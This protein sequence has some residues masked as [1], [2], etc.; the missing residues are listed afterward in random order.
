MINE[1]QHS[2]VLAPPTELAPLKLAVIGFLPRFVA[3]TSFLFANPRR[4]LVLPAPREQRQ[5]GAKAYSLLPLH[6]F[7][8][9]ASLEILEAMT[10]RP[11]PRVAVHIQLW[12]CATGPCDV[13]A[14]VTLA[15]QGRQELLIEGFQ[16]DPVLERVSRR[17]AVEIGP[18][19]PM[20]DVVHE[21]IE[22]GLAA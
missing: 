11:A 13:E 18:V 16:V 7:P 4:C 22:V 20:V 5:K 2:P 19:A 1:P 10:D 9:L 3:Y 21:A 12:E 15:S 6:P 14:A 8:G 17:G